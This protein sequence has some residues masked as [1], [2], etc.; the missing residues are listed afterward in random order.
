[1]CEALKISGLDAAVDDETADFT[2]F[3]PTNKAF[4]ELLGCHSCS[5]TLRHLDDDFLSDLLL[6]HV[7]AGT[8]FFDD[9][10]C[11]KYV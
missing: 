8:V 2:V 7:S 5:N 3:A 10:K 9:L 11:Q 6:F 1:L 4:Q